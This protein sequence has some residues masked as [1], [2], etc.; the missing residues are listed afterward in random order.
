MIFQLVI[1][2][3]LIPALIQALDCPSGYTLN[4]NICYDFR[5]PDTRTLRS[6]CLSQCTSSGAMM[7]C[8]QN[9][10][11]QDYIY[12]RRSSTNFWLGYERSGGG[13][14]WVA[15]CSSSYTHWYPGEGTSGEQYAIMEMG[16]NGLWSDWNENGNLAACVC[17]QTAF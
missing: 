10:D 17:Q 5:N 4:G 12:G 13:F 2:L 15:G 7:L 11:Q 9:Q 3:G 6:T 1:L 8:I 16:V 14:V